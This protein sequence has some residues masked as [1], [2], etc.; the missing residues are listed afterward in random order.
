MTGRDVPT[1]LDPLDPEALAIAAG[2]FAVMAV[3]RYQ[4]RVEA[5]AAQIAE[6]HEDRRTIGLLV[7]L[8]NACTGAALALHETGTGAPG[9]YTRL[10]AAAW[11]TESEVMVGE[12]A[13]PCRQIN[14]SWACARPYGHEGPHRSDPV[15]WV[16]PEPEN[17]PDDPEPV[18]NSPEGRRARGLEPIRSVR[19]RRP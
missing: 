15:E 12:L 9:G 11:L 14:G 6:D 7:D 5:P 18:D 3:E 1:G 19:R 16:A 8:A 4:L 17:A 2:Q 10:P 13:A